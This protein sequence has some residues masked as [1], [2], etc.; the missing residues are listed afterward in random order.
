MLAD[1]VLPDHRKELIHCDFQARNSR[2]D[3]CKN[4]QNQADKGQILRSV[5]MMD[6]RHNCLPR[7]DSY[8]PRNRD[9]APMPEKTP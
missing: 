2:R 8:D 3:D 9:D 5:R 6:K 4:D 1:V 7:T